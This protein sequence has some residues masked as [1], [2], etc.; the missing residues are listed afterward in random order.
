[1]PVM[2]YLEALK[3]LRELDPVRALLMTPGIG[4]SA[5]SELSEG[6]TRG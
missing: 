6:G 5:I 2:R 3:S 4:A 1:M